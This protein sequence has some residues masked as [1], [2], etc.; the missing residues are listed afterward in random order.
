MLYSPAECLCVCV[1][2]LTLRALFSFYSG[3]LCVCIL[4]G[5]FCA[6]IRRGREQG[7]AALF[8]YTAVNSDAASSRFASSVKLPGSSQEHISPL[9]PRIL[10]ED[11]LSL[12]SHSP[13]A[14][15]PLEFGPGGCGTPPSSVQTSGYVK[16]QRDSLGKCQSSVFARLFCCS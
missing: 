3:L 15:P 8:I 13:L 10:W 11:W 9:Y 1:Y 12:S 16:V 7:K 2:A 4:L 5:V 14:G 6:I